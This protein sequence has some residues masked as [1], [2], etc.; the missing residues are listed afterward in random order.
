MYELGL[1]G[2]HSEPSF[3]WGVVEAIITESKYFFIHFFDKG[4]RFSA[5][6]PAPNYAASANFCH[7]KSKM[8]L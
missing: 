1:I 5:K 3:I 7:L 6:K 8:A 4:K 2:L